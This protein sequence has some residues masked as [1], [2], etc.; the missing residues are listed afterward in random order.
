MNDS[1]LSSLHWKG[2]LTGYFQY[3]P[4][5][6]NSSCA[7]RGNW[8]SLGSFLSQS[9][10]GIYQGSSYKPSWMEVLSS[11][12]NLLQ[13]KPCQKYADSVLHGDDSEI[14]RLKTELRIPDESWF[15]RELIFSPIDLI[16]G[17]NDDGFKEHINRIIPTLRDNK[18]YRENGLARLLT[19]YYRCASKEAHEGLKQFSLEVWG[20][21]QLTR[22]VGWGHV[23]P[24]VKEMVQGWLVLEDIRD[25]FDLSRTERTSDKRRFDFWLKYIKQIQYSRIVLGSRAYESQERDYRNLRDRRRGRLS[26]LLSWDDNAFIMKIGEYYFV[27]FSKTGNACYDY[28]ENSLPFQME[29]A[30]YRLSD[31][32]RKNAAVFRGIHRDTWFGNWEE[33][34]AR[35]LENLGIYP[36]DQ[37]Q[38]PPRRASTQSN[39][40]QTEERQSPQNNS[41]AELQAFLQKRGLRV[42]DNRG[43]G[44]YLWVFHNVETGDIAEQLRR[45]GFTY[46]PP[47]QGYWKR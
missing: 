9:F 17:Y 1:R 3:S 34:F 29:R 44:G 14:Q 4:S 22:Q 16:E 13:E 12:L 46:A 28:R 31:L 39:R 37:R 35:E 20:S 30:E 41:E 8:K 40:P 5:E 36:D 24:K 19:R 18:V 45:F 11:N 47:R 10:S 38:S 15:Y 27:E 7:G 2:L 26:R 23:D 25:F 42:T 43:Q 6:D 21:P 33:E 32:K